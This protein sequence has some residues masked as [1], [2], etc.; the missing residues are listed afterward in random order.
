[1]TNS[2][3]SQTVQLQEL[4]EKKCPENVESIVSS[5]EKKIDADL[6]EYVKKLVDHSK[7]QRCQQVSGILFDLASQLISDNLHTFALASD[8]EKDNLKLMNKINNRDG[9][10]LNCKTELSDIL[11]LL[12]I[13]AKQLEEMNLPV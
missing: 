1:M 4:I 7:E 6:K 11:I 10:E 9:N 3:D 13:R 12:S 2:S 8:N 5:P